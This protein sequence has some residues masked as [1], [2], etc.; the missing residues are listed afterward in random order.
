M[1]GAAVAGPVTPATAAPS[2]RAGVAAETMAPDQTVATGPARSLGEPAAAQDSAA[3]VVVATTFGPGGAQVRGWTR[4]TGSTAWRAAGPILPGGFG[5]S[6]DA[7]A[8]ASPGGPLLVVAGVSP[9][10]Q[11]CIADGS[12]AIVNVESTGRLGP[13]R[14]VSDQR[15][16]G[17]FDDRPAVAVG[18]DGT[19]W[20]AWSQGP[21]ADACQ[22]VGAGDRLEVAVSH[23]GGRTFAAPVTM[24]AGGGDSAFGARLAPLP[25]GR[26]AVSWVESTGHG[27]E[28]VLVS[29]LGPGGH[30]SRSQ[31]VLTGDG[32][33]LT[34][35]GASFYD[36]PAGDIT[37]LPSGR[38]VVAMPFWEAGHAVIGLGSGILGEPWQTSDIEPPE[39]A[40]LLLPAL[41]YLSP[42]AV[43]LLCA[44]HTRS[45]D[46]LGYDWTDLRLDTQGHV[47]GPA[48]LAALTSSP[49]GPGFF[50]IGEELSISRAPD[51]LLSAM[52][53][54]GSG[55]ALLE[56]ESWGLPRPAS[57]PSP[58]PRSAAASSPAQAG[59]SRGSRSPGAGHTGSL[60]GRPAAWTA[61]AVIACAALLASWAARRRRRA[62]RG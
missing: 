44:V 17:S 49:A 21:D 18:L 9:G 60:W 10:G 27:D 29:V 40:D 34:L 22:N 48:G 23:D 56:T 32:L 30:P 61:A 11:P 16:T 37:A 45:G 3:G 26:V 13:A 28:A 6:Y 2:N 50:E 4:P 46:R 52:V 36:F 47:L 59:G 20:V 35:P 5:S 15:G 25:G 19:V 12:V 8:A 7:S 43:R 54:A 57:T 53:V 1:F 31:R 55:G 41:A 33:P 24:P 39:G 62:P 42:A 51:G 58:R 38:L 14:L